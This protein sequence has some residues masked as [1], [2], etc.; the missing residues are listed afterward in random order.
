MPARTDN[1]DDPA[2][3]AALLLARRGTA[4]FARKLNELPD[5]E[6][7]GPS[8]LPGWDRA[9]VI[10]HVGY[11][12]RAL[13]HLTEWAATGVEHAMYE[14][15]EARAREIDYGASLSPTALRNLSAHASVH[16]NVEWRDLPARAWQTQIR[17]ANGRLVPASETVWM[18]SRE[19]WIHAIDLNNGARFSELPATFIDRLL[20]DITATWESRPH[21]AGDRFTLTASDRD[22]TWPR[23]PDNVRTPTP[24]S[25]TAAQLARWATGRGAAAAADDQEIPRAPR[26]I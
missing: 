22:R 6:F 17:T 25:G 15:P 19:V 7:N 16:L 8:L 9:H 14:S 1:V 4:Y 13:T 20:D 10:A 23:R 3:A 12:A 2:L 11:N 24:I 18:R 26:W 21:T 5:R